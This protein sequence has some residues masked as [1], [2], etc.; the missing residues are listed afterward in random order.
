MKSPPHTVTVG[1]F[2]SR[3]E[4]RKNY[5]RQVNKLKS[6]LVEKEIEIEG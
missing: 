4:V 3:E 6:S 2:I 1:V 5:E